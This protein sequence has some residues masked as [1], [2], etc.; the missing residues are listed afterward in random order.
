M[1]TSRRSLNYRGLGWRGEPINGDGPGL[2]AAI[3]ADATS[4]A[5]VARVAGRMHAVVT[6][7][8]SKLKA[9]WRARLDAKPASFALFH[10]D[11]DIAACWSR[12]RVPHG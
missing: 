12:H 9:L 4:S 3:E 10:I 6:Q 1:F 7:F 5:F 2:R 8:W 11:F